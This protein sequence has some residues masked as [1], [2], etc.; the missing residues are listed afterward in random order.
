MIVAENILEKADNLFHK[1]GVRSISMDDIARELGI[2]K[3]TIYQYFKDKDDIVY[4]MTQRRIEIDKNEFSKAYESSEDAIDELIKVSVCLRKNL[5]RVNPALLFDIQKY[6]PR[7]WDLW[8]DYK[9]NYIRNYVLKSIERGKR[10][11]FFRS[12]LDAETLATFRIETVQMSFDDR[13]F[14]HDK[15]NFTEVQMTLFDHF[16]HGLLTVKGHE[17]Y[18]NLIK[19]QVNV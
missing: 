3:K 19:S 1:Y 16:V 18:Q 13:I 12:T 5:N 17:I 11:G 10:E 9:N 15:F 7:S 4:Q 14:P 6:H 8:I 2:S